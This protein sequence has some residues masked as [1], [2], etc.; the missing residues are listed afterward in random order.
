MNE[1]IA[2]IERSAHSQS[3]LIEDLLDV[4]RMVSG[5]LRLHAEEM[6]LAPVAHEA[7]AVVK[8]MADAKNIRLDSII[9]PAAGR[10]LADAGR[11]QQVIWNLLGNAVK[12]T[13][14]GGRVSVEL[15]R[16]A[17]HVA[18]RIQDSGEGIASTFLSQ[19]FERFR[20]ADA[21]SSRRHGGLGLGLAITKQ[22][23]ELH[24]GS[25]GVESLGLG[26]GATF[27]VLMPLARQEPRSGD[28][29]PP[30]LEG[31][32][33][34]L[35]E[36]EAAARAGLTLVLEHAG[37]EVIATASA[38]AALEALQAGALSD[39][40]PDLMLS[41][42]GLPGE[43][44]HALMRA[45]RTLPNQ[46]SGIPSLAISAYS[47]ADHRERAH[48]SGFQGYVVK[49]IDL[50]LLLNAVLR[51]VGRRGTASIVKGR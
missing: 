50:E 16:Q 33:I 7:L 45:V 41:D 14:A 37:A 6:E 25:V 42:I 27:T 48:Q 5:Q 36:D 18:I 4:S 19:V 47:S 17:Q 12:F 51:L 24:G 31:L 28:A 20:Q 11:M 3:R 2:A 39:Q 44:G 43:D 34:L 26:K 22:L 15:R 8:A 35:V 38:R 21:A 49:P 9:D 32:R 13:P 30:R 10:V 40:L 1:A 29:A 46:A 23:V